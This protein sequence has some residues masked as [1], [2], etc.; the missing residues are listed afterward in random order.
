[1][2]PAPRIVGLDIHPWA[3]REAAETYRSFGLAATSQQR[4][5][6]TATFPKGR[7]AILAAFALNELTDTA[8][9]PLLARLAERAAHGDR[10][11]VI[12]P[13]AGGVARWWNR[14]RD[15]I[16][17]AGGRAD[18]WRIRVELPAIVAKLDRAAGLDHREITGRSLFL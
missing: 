16:E 6:A 15:T 4:D 14:W 10:V 18:E 17:R 13:L 3:V 9:E 8:R 2:T 5:I 11:L 12:E 1:V 7:A